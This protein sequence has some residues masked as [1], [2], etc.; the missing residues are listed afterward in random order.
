MWS[1]SGQ[2]SS[3]FALELDSDGRD[4]G[5]SREVEDDLSSQEIEVREMVVRSV[6]VYADRHIPSNQGEEV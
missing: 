3:A 6:E 4:C 5:I 2:A 1:R